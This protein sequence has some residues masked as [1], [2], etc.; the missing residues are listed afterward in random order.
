[1]VFSIGSIKNYV[2]GI[3]LKH[4]W[5][6]RKKDLCGLNLQQPGNMITTL[7]DSKNRYNVETI[8]SKLRAGSKL[9]VGEMQ[10]LREHHPDLYIKAKKIAMERE[11]YERELRRCKTKEEVR[12][13]KM[14]KTASF[15]AEMKNA[16]PGGD[17]GSA[18][19]E[20]IMRSNAITRAHLEFTKSKE[21]N[22]LPED[23]HELK[24][25][26]K[27]GRYVIKA[28]GLRAARADLENLLYDAQARRIGKA[29]DFSER[30]SKRVSETA[31]PAQKQQF[32]DG[33]AE[34]S[35]QAPETQQKTPPPETVWTYNRFSAE[36]AATKRK[37]SI[38]ARV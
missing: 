12:R 36:S 24:E 19:D 27:T 25:R 18:G 9:S 32:A 20:I 11:A 16:S 17:A 35:S 38:L 30:A 23:Y 2:K 7:L 33:Q 29:A 31:A 15:L 1:M 3:E 8:S 22:N 14:H 37:S 4:K 5:D 26:R 28:A 21:Y 13:A 6:Q 34:L 10:Y